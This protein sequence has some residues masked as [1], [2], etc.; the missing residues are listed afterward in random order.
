MAKAPSW[1]RRWSS[2]T[3]RPVGRR[4]ARRAAPNAAIGVIDRA[5]ATAPI[6]AEGNSLEILILAQLS[7]RAEVQRWTGRSLP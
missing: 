6:S 3:S 1:N 5:L 4:P 2:K 7:K